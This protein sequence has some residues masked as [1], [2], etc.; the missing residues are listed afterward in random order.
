MARFLSYLT[1]IEQRITNN[2]FMNP[3]KNDSTQ[4]MSTLSEQTTDA[5]ESGYTEN[6]KVDSK[7]LT[8][9]EKN[10][11]SP[12]DVSINNF[13]RFEG[14]SDP[15]ENCILYLISTPDGKRGMLIDAY[16]VNADMKISNFIRDVEDIQKKN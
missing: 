9:D 5:F 12:T 15:A 3:N 8:V 6:F 16:G 7:G 14:Y 2:E 13:Y 11:Y 1:N 4:K 10:Y